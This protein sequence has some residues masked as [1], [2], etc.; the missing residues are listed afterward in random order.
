MACTI[1][2][3]GRLV[4]WWEH[5]QATKA[6]YLVPEAT[7]GLGDLTLYRVTA[8]GEDLSV[9][10]PADRPGLHRSPPALSPGE[11]GQGESDQALLPRP[12]AQVKYE[13]INSSIS[14]SSTP[15]VSLVSRPVRS[16]LTSAIRG[17]ARSG[18]SGCPSLLRRA[19]HAIAACSASRFSSSTSSSFELA[20]SSSR[21]RGS[22]AASARSGTLPRCQSAC[23]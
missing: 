12:T 22:E 13:R 20:A 9:R 8:P 19:R 21:S 4:N 10:R 11:R 6:A 15:A 14:P 5:F 17:R 23:A 18:G 3:E 16:S 2:S 1:R 7:S